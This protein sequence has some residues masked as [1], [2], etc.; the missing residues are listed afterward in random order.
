M[1][2]S[3]AMLKAHFMMLASVCNMQL[4]QMVLLGC[5]AS[6]LSVIQRWLASL[7]L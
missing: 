3:M 1:Q 5:S 4:L 2:A 6:F 7:K